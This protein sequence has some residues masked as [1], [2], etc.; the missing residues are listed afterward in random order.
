VRPSLVL[1]LEDVLGD[2][3]DEDEDEYGGHG[4]I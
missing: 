4:F 1:D 3:N 2:D